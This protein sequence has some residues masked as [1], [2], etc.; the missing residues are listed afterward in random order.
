MHNPDQKIRWQQEASSIYDRLWDVV[1]VGAGPAGATA[2]AYLAACHHSVLLLDRQKFPREKVCGDGL[3]PDALRCLDGMGIGNIVRE[4]GNKIDTA[5]IFSP[6]QKELQLSGSYLT[7]KRF[8]LDMIIVRRSVELGTVFA[9]GEVERIRIDTDGL[10]I[11]ESKE[12]NWKFCARVGVVAT[13]ADIKLLRQMKWSAKKNPSA[14]ALRCY[15]R[16]AYAIDRL[17]VSFDRSILPGYAWIFPLKNHEYNV[18]CGITLTRPQVSNIN[19]KRI[20][21]N[22]VG[23]FPLARELLRQSFGRTALK[24]VALRCDFEGV[25]PFVKDNIVVVGETIGTTLPFLGEG[26]GKA[27]ESGKMAADA[28]NTALDAEDFEM[29]MQYGRQI[30][31]KLKPRYHGYRIAEKWMTKPLLSNFIWSR[32]R[33]SKF[34]QNILAGIVNETRDPSEIFSWKSVLKTFWK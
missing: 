5:A 23:E 4:E 26:I 6:S 22:F 33:K 17:I 34:A 27:M 31:T 2:A 25:S 32:S 20:F 29:L 11:F 19:L 28:I 7:I 1:I 30:E 9:F 13:G 12:G 21:N 16:S 18:G 10:V 24:G 3:L 8:L 15:I 14:I